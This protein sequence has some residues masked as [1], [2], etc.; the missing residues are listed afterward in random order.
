MNSDRFIRR[1][2]I[3]D[4]QELRANDSGQQFKISCPRITYDARIMT[5]D[6]RLRLCIDLTPLTLHSG[7]QEIIERI[8]AKPFW[9]VVSDILA[10]SSQLRVYSP[11]GQGKILPLGRIAAISQLLLHL[12][13]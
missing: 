7:D 6:D 5:A 11:E 1:T 9:P 13:V 4:V 8:K 3:L 2:V 12:A 10:E